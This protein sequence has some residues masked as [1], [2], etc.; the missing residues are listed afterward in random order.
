MYGGPSDQQRKRRSELSSVFFHSLELRRIGTQL[1]SG[2]QSIEISRSGE[3][4]AEAGENRTKPSED[5]RRV[6]LLFGIVLSTH[7][8]LEGSGIVEET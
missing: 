1:I 8:Y 3:H 7:L 5:P 6:A 2:V 4:E